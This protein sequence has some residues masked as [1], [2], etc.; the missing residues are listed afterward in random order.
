MDPHL[1]IQCNKTLS[2][3]ETPTH[4]IFLSQTQHHTFPTSQLYSTP[5]QQQFVLTPTHI[6]H[7]TPQH[8]HPYTA[9]PTHVPTHHPTHPTK[10]CHSISQL[11]QTFSATCNKY[12]CHPY[13]VNHRHKCHCIATI[14][15]QTRFNLF[16]LFVKIYASSGDR[17]SICCASELIILRH[18][19]SSSIVSFIILK[20]FSIDL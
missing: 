9:T 15:L 7:H 17:D 5:P 3:K 10:V 2:N 20:F 6:Y 1:P 16:S 8:T 4:H 14:S 18:F 12:Q 13:F 11:Q 19:L